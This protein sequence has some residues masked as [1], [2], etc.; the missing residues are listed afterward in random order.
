MPDEHQ[1][2]APKSPGS[3]DKNQKKTKI[4][5]LQNT[6]VQPAQSRTVPPP[7]P[8]VEPIINQSTLVADSLAR[9]EEKFVSARENLHSSRLTSRTIQEQEI[10]Q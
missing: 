9:Q 4:P 10:E 6:E 3:K 5:T 7:P 8:L 2:D 1:K